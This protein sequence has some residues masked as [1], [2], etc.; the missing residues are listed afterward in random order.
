MLQHIRF[1]HVTRV[2]YNTH[3]VCLGHISVKSLD[4]SII[5]CYHV[6]KEADPIA[7]GLSVCIDCS[8]CTSTGD[9]IY[10]CIDYTTQIW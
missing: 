8:S 9:H 7:V 10:I 2:L 6:A 4:D 1:I 5:L 3:P